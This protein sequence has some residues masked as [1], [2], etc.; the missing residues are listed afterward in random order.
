MV[1][2]VEECGKRQLFTATNPRYAAAQNVPTS[3]KA[4][5]SDGKAGSGVYSVLPDG[6]S[7]PKS[8]ENVLAKQRKNGANDAIWAHVLEEFE[9]ITEVARF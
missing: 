4:R 1:T 5:G 6:E 8:I 9:R 7:A 3:D 2:S